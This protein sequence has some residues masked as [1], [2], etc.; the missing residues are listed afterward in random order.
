MGKDKQFPEVKMTMLLRGSEC[1][2]T[3]GVQRSTGTS[4]EQKTE[5]DA[6]NWRSNCR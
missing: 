6:W 3:F 2:E 1:L 5:T 4:V